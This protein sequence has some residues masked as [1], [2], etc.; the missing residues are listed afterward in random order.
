M[1]DDRCP[2]R[3]LKS[4]VERQTTSSMNHVFAQFSREPVGLRFVAEEV[5]C[6]ET[7]VVV[8]GRVQELRTGDL[9]REFPVALLWEFEDS[10][11]SGIRQFAS[12]EQALAAV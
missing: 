3:A 5:E 9:Q 7:H 11:V 8:V 1:A 10:P 4:P 6:A 12:K 2:E